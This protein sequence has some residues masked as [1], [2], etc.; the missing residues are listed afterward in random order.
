M[1]GR[2]LKSAIA[3]END[4]KQKH[5]MNP[6]SYSLYRSCVRL[7]SHSRLCNSTTG[8]PE[9]SFKSNHCLPRQKDANKLTSNKKHNT[10]YLLCCQ[11]VAHCAFKSTFKCWTLYG[12]PLSYSPALNLNINASVCVIFSDFVNKKYHFSTHAFEVNSWDAS[13][14]LT[15]AEQN[16]FLRRTCSCEKCPPC[17][18]FNK[19]LMAN[20]ECLNEQS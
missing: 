16:T 2:C 20:S 14:N 13:W 3:R 17:F 8:W 7:Y 1:F 9:C 6:V 11:N 15:K 12:L 18:L 4:T 10:F 5:N 19:L